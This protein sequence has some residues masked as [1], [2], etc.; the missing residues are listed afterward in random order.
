[1]A[2]RFVSHFFVLQTVGLYVLIRPGPYICA[3]RDGGGL[4]FWLYRDHPDIKLRS[5]D[6]NFLTAVG[7]WWNVLLPIMKPL[8]YQNGGPIILVQVRLIC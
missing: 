5:S 2:N 3:E 7:S 8:L 4:P 6:P 1:M